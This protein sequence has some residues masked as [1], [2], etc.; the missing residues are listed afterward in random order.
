MSGN[1]NDRKAYDELLLGIV[2]E[3]KD[4]LSEFRKDITAQVSALSN[5]MAVM[6]TKAMMIGI[7]CGGITSVFFSIITTVIIAFFKKPT[8]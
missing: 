1:E 4:Q 5:R 6:E 3:T 7:I 8:P 2:T